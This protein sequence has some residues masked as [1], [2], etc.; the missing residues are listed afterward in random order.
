MIS[1]YRDVIKEFFAQTW[2]TQ[3]FKFMDLCPSADAHKETL[4]CPSG[5]GS[6]WSS[7]AQLLGGQLAAT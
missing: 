5:H 4:D 1:N 7:F 2:L 6:S 3:C